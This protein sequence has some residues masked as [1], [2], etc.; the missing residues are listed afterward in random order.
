MRF[1]MRKTNSGL[2]S[3]LLLSLFLAKSSPVRASLLPWICSYPQSFASHPE[4]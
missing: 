3:F 1:T 4:G 2:G